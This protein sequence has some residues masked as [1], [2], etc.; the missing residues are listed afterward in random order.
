MI[1]KRSRRASLLALLLALAPGCARLLAPPHQPIAEDAQRA[2]TLVARRWSEFSDLRTLADLDV[3]R[4]RD[5]QRLRSVV[6]AKAPASVRFEALSPMG[7]PF[8]IATVHDGGLV[9]YNV[10]TNE[11]VV[12]PATAHTMA[13]LLSLPFEPDDLVGVLAGRPAPLPDVRVA[14][15]MP[16]D[17][18]G[19]SLVVVNNVHQQRIWMDFV[20][21]VVRQVEITGGLYEVRV[22]YDRGPQGDVQGFRFSAPRANVTGRVEYRDAVVDGGVDDNRFRM[23]PPET[24]KIQRVR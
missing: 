1:R 18:D 10:A 4:G 19:P 11:A 16:G 13:T 7:Q 24:A 9:V 21:G 2:L 14:E 12:G 23:T 20:T 5:R 3:A 15:M 6:L 17:A 22:T 8:L